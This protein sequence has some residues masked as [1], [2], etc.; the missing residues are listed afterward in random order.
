M[1]KK[2]FLIIIILAI[3]IAFL[4][5][6]FSV[7]FS[8]FALTIQKPEKDFLKRAARKA[9]SIIY[10]EATI[11]NPPG[12]LVPDQIDDSMKGKLKEIIN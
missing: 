6:I 1:L 2:L 5:G 10:R 3:A 4:G 11:H 7:S 12:D 9:K 8:P